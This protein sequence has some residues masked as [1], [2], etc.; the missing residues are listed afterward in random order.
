MAYDI[1]QQARS[2]ELDLLDIKLFHLC[3]ALETAFK[4]WLALKGQVPPTTHSIY[5]LANMVGNQCSADFPIPDEFRPVIKYLNGSYGTKMY[6]YPAHGRPVNF[7]RTLG[8]WPRF[9]AFIRSCIQQLDV[10]LNTK[11][12]KGAP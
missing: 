4:G 8:A 2:G 5:K 3:R 10:A 7:I 1:I 12:R 11:T 9:V 6:E